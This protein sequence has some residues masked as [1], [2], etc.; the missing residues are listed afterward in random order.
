MMR[1]ATNFFAPIILLFFFLLHATGDSGGPLVLANALGGSIANGRPNLD[2]ILGIVSFGPNPCA[3]EGI[4]GVY[5]RVSS[6][7]DWVNVM[8]GQSTNTTDFQI[9]E[10]PDPE[11]KNEFT[12][13]CPTF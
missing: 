5:T 12:E 2:I 8:I 13:H 9:P 3:T 10:Q 11:V 1:M 6:F 7:V 4:P